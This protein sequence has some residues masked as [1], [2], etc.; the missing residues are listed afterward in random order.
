[1][2]KILIFT[3]LFTGAFT[4][5]FTNSFATE[6]FYTPFTGEHLIWPYIPGMTLCKD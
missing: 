5:T 6:T 3:L 4:M 1:M 2:N